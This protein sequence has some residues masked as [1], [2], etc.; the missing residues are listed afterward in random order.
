MTRQIASVDPDTNLLECARKMVRKRI[1]DLPL[2]RDKILKGFISTQDILWAIVKK[3]KEDL[4]KIKA[5]DIS[6]RKIMTIRPDASIEEAVWKMK[7]F[8]FHRLPVVKNSELLGLITIRDILTFY[9]ELNVHLKEVEF[10]REETE[11][12]KRLE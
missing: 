9:P 1:N 8:K 3:S 2:V 6:P 10:V 11:K 4:S 5:S 12:I 7:K